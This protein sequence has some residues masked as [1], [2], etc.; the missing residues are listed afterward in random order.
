MYRPMLGYWN[1]PVE[2][3]AALEN[4]LLHTGD[5][6]S[7]CASGHLRVVGRKSQVIIR[8]GANV[9]PAEVERVLVEAPGV[10]ACAVVGVP[11][12][13]LGERVGAAVETVP[14]AVVDRD[15]IVA[16]CREQLA[17]YKVPER[18]VFLERLP[19]NQMG[20]VPSGEIRRLLSDRSVSDAG[21]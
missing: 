14:G 20:K 2:S 9:Y 7:V 17:A 15:A 4:G 12:D 6:G 18:F 16:Y 21:A 8:G 3:E 5:L 13:R 10:R 1:K 11:D 19:R